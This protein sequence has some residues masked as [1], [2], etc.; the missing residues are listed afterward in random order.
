MKKTLLTVVAAL[1]F[2]LLSAQTAKVQVIHNSSD[3]AADSVDVY[4]NG[5]L[6]LNNFAYRTATPYLDLPAGSY[7]IAVAP[8]TSVN[9]GSAIY[10][11]PSIALTGGQNYTVIA[12][13][14]LTGPVATAFDL[15]IYNQSRLTSSM[16]GNTD[17]LVFHGATDA[18]TVDVT[19]AGGT[20]TLSNDL[21]YSTFNSAGYLELPTANYSIEVRDQ[22][23]A[24]VVAGY[25]APL[26]TL[27]LTNAAITV[28]ASGF[29]A[30]AP[31]QAA[32]GLYV[33]LPSGGNL[34]P[35]PQSLSRVQVIHNSSDV[36]ADSVDIYFDGSLVIN[37]FAFRTATPFIDITS[38]VAHSIAVAPKTSNTVADAIATFPVSFAAN[39]KY[40]VVA[41]GLLS[42]PLA[43]QFSLYP[44]ALGRE[45]SNMMGNTDVLI[46]HGSTDA[47]TVDVTVAGGTPTISNDLAYSTFNSAG[48]L[49]LPT[50]N[51]SI[52]VRDQSGATVVAGYE[53]PLQTLGLTNAAIA[54]VASGFLAPAP[55]QAAFGLYAALS[56]GGN[57][58]P[59]PQSKS[60]LQV[61]HNSSDVAADSVD[62]YLDGALLLNNFAFRTATPFIDITS[63]VAHSIAVAPK[64]STSVAGAIATFPVSFAANEKYVVVANGL[65]SGPVATQFSLYP[66]ALAR[67]TANATGNTDVLIFHGSTDAPIVDV[68]VAGGTPTL[69]D[70]LAYSTY[71]SAGYLALPTADYSIEVRDQT[72]ATVVAAYDAPLQTLGL[73][74]AAITVVASGFLAPA[75]GQAAFGLY[76]AL[77][78]GGNLVPLP[79]T[80]TVGIN[81]L[82]VNGNVKLYPNPTSSVLNLNSVDESILFVSIQDVNGKELYNDSKVNANTLAIDLSSF[83]SGL[84]TIKVETKTSLNVE[85]LIITK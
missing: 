34:V 31:G 84:Y 85:K 60:R 55:G 83:E 12:N 19:V 64:T 18:P 80:A 59:L 11:S 37:N 47:P 62:V 58:V 1:G 53:A 32:F 26:Q 7:T 21:A 20:P 39:E 73:T 74:N 16:M 43:T 81:D 13:G 17:L 48:Y 76:A 25:E 82:T 40:V 8:K 4:V 36:A 54:V 10:T 35:L 45:T 52:E 3:P 56:S 44:Y 29:L 41:N 46:F 15:Y 42:G 9:V 2:G 77:S 28:V 63:G 24:T 22:S 71:N 67:E 27:G 6:T 51:Y 5:L 30:P 50:A 70:N 61:I 14:L 38:G 79:L 66:Y 49:E 75:T 72:G 78:S 57:L 68:T 33:A 23:G 65:L 69:A